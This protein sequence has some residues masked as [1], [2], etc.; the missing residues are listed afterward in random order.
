MRLNFGLAINIVHEIGHAVWDF[1][2]SKEHDAYKAKHGR[3]SRL[4]FDQDIESSEIGLAW[5]DTTLS[6]VFFIMA[7]IPVTLQ[8]FPKGEVPAISGW[9]DSS[10]SG[11][12][13]QSTADGV[14]DDEE[15]DKVKSTKNW[16]GDHTPPGETMPLENGSKIVEKDGNPKGQRKR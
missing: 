16:V 5:E 13:S 11:V 6:A 10:E 7:L 3:Q 14:D 2:R 8:C 9:Y 15:V 4:H 12:S 1:A